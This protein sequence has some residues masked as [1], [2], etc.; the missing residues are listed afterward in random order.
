MEPLPTKNVRV[1]ITQPMLFP[2]GGFFE[3]LMLAD[4]YV[5]LD[6]VQFSKGSLTNRIQILTG[7]QRSWMT[8][9]LLNKGSFQLI[10]DLQEANQSW[11]VDHKN[12]LYNALKRQPFINDVMDIVG[13]AY[14]PNQLIEILVASIESSAKYLGIGQERRLSR[15]SDLSVSSSSSERVLELAKTVGGTVYVTGHGAANYLDHSLFEE[16]GISVEYMRY[17]CTP[18]PQ[19]CTEF[20]PYVSILDMIARTGP[21]AIE[22]LK[23]QTVPWREFVSERTSPF[24]APKPR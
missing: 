24:D 22:F 21:N 14:K 8:I 6:D 18:Y 4:E 7:S 16:A 15:S 23:P 12:L 5:Y 1:V 10:S 11:K 17:S 13:E 20:M 19:P 3:Q 2:W 9:P